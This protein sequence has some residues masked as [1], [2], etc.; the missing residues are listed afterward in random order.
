[1]DCVWHIAI[2]IVWVLELDVS[3]L[4]VVCEDVYVGAWFL[5][6][7]WGMIFLSQGFNSPIWYFC[8]VIELSFLLSFSW[9]VD[10]QIFIIENLTIQVA[11]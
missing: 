2:Q 9:D 7:I 3:N 10:A 1:M 8:L 5:N 11:N 6:Y 4:R